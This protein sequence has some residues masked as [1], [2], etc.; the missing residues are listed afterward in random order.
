PKFPCLYRTQIRPFRN[1]RTPVIASMTRT[2][3][4]KALAVV[5][6]G[7]A[8]VRTS[9]LP[10]FV[11]FPLVVL[12]SF[13]LSS[14][15]YSLSAPYTGLELAAV[16][17]RLER[18]DEVV[19]LVGWRG[20]ELAL[21]WWGGYDGYDLAALSL[22]SHGPPL[23]LLSTFYSIRTSTVLNSLL[24]D[25]LTTYIPFRLLRSLSPA[26]TASPY[27]NISVPNREI[28][29]D[30]TVQAV[31][32]LLAAS[33]YSVTLYSAYVTHLPL[34]L[35]TYFEGIPT[36]EYAYR[37]TPFTLLPLSL[38]LGLA[39][40]SF[41][42]T[43]AAVIVDKRQREFDPS[44]ASFEETVRWNVWG[45]GD[46]TKVVIKRTAALALVSGVNTFVQSW[47]TIEGVEPL[48]AAAYAG[49][50]VVA[51]AISGVALGVVGAV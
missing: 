8:P 12:L 51:A 38:V 2:V 5:K 49:I 35:A 18:W 15:L 48:G 22:L 29:T 40:K 34:Y 28:L 13:T 46:K 4:E 26:H 50:W 10:P 30:T 44:K 3:K 24:I 9:T 14:F 31:T 19:G 42:F 41:I 21:G 23:Y 17:R 36:I 6:D 11:R 32:T 7:E 45:Y 1:Y 43:P 39:A 25:V 37:A 33:I 16:S 20:I 47:V 27:S